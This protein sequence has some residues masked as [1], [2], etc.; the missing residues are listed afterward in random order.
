MNL[1]EFS[2]RSLYA[3]KIESS[4]FVLCNPIDQ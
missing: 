1:L 2:I 4:G 3:Y